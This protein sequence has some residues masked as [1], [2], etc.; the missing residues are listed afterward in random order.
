MLK[1]YRISAHLIWTYCPSNAGHTFY[2]GNL[3]VSITAVYIP[4]QASTEDAMLNLCKDL[5]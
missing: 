1:Y 3:H 4:P 2:Q 5:N